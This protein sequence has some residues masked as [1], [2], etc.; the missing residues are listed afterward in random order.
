MKKILIY[1]DRG[2]GRLS[3]SLLVKALQ[4]EELKAYS[5]CPIDRHELKKEK[6]EAETALLIMPGGRDVFYHQALRGELNQRLKYFVE[7]G[8]CYLGLCAGGY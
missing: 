3:I 8:G 4:R 2:V 5:I 7:Q 1:E 6:W